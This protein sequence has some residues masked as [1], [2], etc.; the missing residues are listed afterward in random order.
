MPIGQTPASLYGFGSEPATV[1]TGP[2]L[3]KSGYAGG[4]RR[5]RVGGR[6]GACRRVV[7]MLIGLPGRTD[8]AVVTEVLTEGGTFR[9]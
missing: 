4:L 1:V 8:V 3:M 9:P 2:S 5:S 6:E 7:A